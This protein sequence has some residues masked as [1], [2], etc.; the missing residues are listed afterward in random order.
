M[1]F[2]Q[3]LIYASGDWSQVSLRVPAITNTV[4]VT[5]TRQ[6]PLCG[7]NTRTGKT[8]APTRSSKWLVLE[9]KR[10]EKILLFVVDERTL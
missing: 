3:T 1:V 4:R 8:Q 6:T 5:P 9:V 7:K 10:E 2:I